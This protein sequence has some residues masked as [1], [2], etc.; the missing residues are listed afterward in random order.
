MAIDHK[1]HGMSE[2]TKGLISDYHVLEHDFVMFAKNAILEFPNVPCS[3]FAHSM[4]TL[5]AALSLPELPFVKCV[6]FSGCCINAGPAAASP[7]GVS[8]LYPL[9]QTSAA[10]HLTAIMARW[11]QYKI[12][13]IVDNIHPLNRTSTLSIIYY[14]VSRRQ[15]LLHLC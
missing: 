15:V 6:C 12:C 7:F 9:S 2:G 10:V 1:G 13:P 8:C 11:G 5:V 14:T 4:G 3:L